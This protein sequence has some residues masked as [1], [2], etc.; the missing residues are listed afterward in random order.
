MRGEMDILNE[1]KEGEGNVRKKSQYRYFVL[2]DKK[3]N[4]D[5]YKYWDLEEE[6]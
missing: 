4:K 1:F 2:L 6:K 3:V 5:D